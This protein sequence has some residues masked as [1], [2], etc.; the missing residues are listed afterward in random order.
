MTAVPL[1]LLRLGI[2]LI[3]AAALYF[4][5]R[6]L[7]NYGLRHDSGNSS[8]DDLAHDSTRAGYQRSFRKSALVISRSA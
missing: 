5:I 6:Y 2:L 7:L 8:G 4:T 3:V 1:I